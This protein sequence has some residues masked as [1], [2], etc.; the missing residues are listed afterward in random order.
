MCGS[1]VKKDPNA[2]I[3]T[4]DKEKKKSPKK[5][6]SKKSTMELPPGGLEAFASLVPP[7]EVI[8]QEKKYDK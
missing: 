3:P 8:A 4:D 6:L 7:D 1:P 2:D 5:K